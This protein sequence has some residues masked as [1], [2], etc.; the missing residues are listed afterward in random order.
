MGFAEKH[1]YFILGGIIR[2]DFYKYLV[3]FFPQF[4]R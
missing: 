1:V 4:Q 3:G 2:L